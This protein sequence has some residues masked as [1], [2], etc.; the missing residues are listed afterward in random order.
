VLT[1]AA[2]RS[3]APVGVPLYFGLAL[4][5]S[6]LFGGPNALSSKS[7]TTAMAASPPLALG[8]FSA[9]ILLTLPIARAAL[10]V[11]QTFFL[12]AM[13]VPRWQFVAIS[14][15][16]L[17]VVELP[18]IALWA[19]GEGAA[20]ALTAAAA[21]V[22]AH[23]LLI[24]RELRA[25]S[26]AAVI[27]VLIAVAAP[28]PVP[29]AVR[30]V[31]ALVAAC[32]GVSA[33]W[34]RAPERATKRVG[35]PLPKAPV[36][37]LA[38]SYLIAIRRGDPAVFGRALLMTALGGIAAPIAARG[39]QIESAAGLSALSLGIATATVAI[40]AS[41]IARAVLRAERRARW[42][43]DASGTGAM[44]RVIAATGASA[45]CAAILGALHGGLVSIGAFAA[46]PMSIR[47]IGLGVVWGALLGALASWNARLSDSEG[48]R[49]GGRAMAR[50]FFV[51][52]AV[53]I[54]V[55]MLGEVALALVAL[56][57]L[58]LS[59][60]SVRGAATPP[61]PLCAHWTFGG[62]AHRRAP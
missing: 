20:P 5:A 13:P 14:A 8:L 30:S 50:F 4:V 7:V 57:T 28:M 43:L 59:A 47:L 16:H 19:R 38:T 11:P 60:Q 42:L 37:A 6:I 32:I 27:A 1:T 2:V 36:A 61:E 10:D 54:A 31:A 44:A 17:A 39:H 15:A 33:A 62:S 23:G 45:A 9:W 24:A 40:A 41:G 53:I 22:G 52:A 21:A 46:A 49:A 25:G 51:I 48:P 29:G 18:W 26:V 34:R 56:A 55:V 58:A 3:A 12:R 35:V